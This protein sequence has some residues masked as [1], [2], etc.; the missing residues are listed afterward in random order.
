MYTD[1]QRRQLIKT[2]E[3]L[4]RD[5]HK[6]EEIAK[7]LGYA[8]RNI[9]QASLIYH[10]RCIVKINKSNAVKEKVNG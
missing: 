3:S 7:L 4:R 10:K 8:D 2:M 5:G 1:K 9:A 6:W